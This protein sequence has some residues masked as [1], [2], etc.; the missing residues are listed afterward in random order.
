MQTGNQNAFARTLTGTLPFTFKILMKKQQIPNDQN[1]VCPYCEKLLLDIQEEEPNEF[2][3]H[4]VFVWISDGGMVYQKPGIDLDSDEDFFIDVEDYAKSLDIDILHYIF[5][6]A[7]SN[8]SSFWGF[9]A[10]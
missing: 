3:S 2:C 8:L 10:E 4:V 6:A 5:G 9:K 7:P 1:I